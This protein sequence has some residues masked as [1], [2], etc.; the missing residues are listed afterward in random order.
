MAFKRM[1]DAIE[2]HEGEP[3]RVITTGIPSIPGNSVYEQCMWLREH[4]D[5]IRLLMLR[6]PRGIPATCANLIV[7]AKDPRAAAGFIIMEQTEYP[8]MSGGNT[9]AVATALLETGLLP[10]QEPVTEFYLEAP[11]GL[12]H[13]TAACKR[14]KVT[15][16]TFKNVPAFAVHLDREIEVPQLGRVKVDIAWGGMFYTV[17]DATQFSW[18]KL[19]PEMGRE[20]ARISALCTRAAMDQLPVAHPDYPGVGIT[21]SIM[22]A[23]PVTPGTSM[24]SSNVVLRPARDLDR[25]SRSRLLRHRDLRPD[26]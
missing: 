16:V 7:P 21:L 13:I 10:M 20:I 24:R 18:L 26:G 22:H 23:P 12:I 25:R 9:M 3:L 4:D 17:I 14:G 1:F 2:V 19:V 6:E 11:A 15:Q 8:M 5:Q